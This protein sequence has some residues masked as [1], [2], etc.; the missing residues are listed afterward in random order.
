MKKCRHAS[1]GLELD[2]LGKVRP[3]CLAK[4]FVDD[5]GKEYSLHET[6]LEEIWN[7]NSRKQLL[8]DLE[9]GIEN[10]ICD[11]CWIEERHGRES[12]RNRENSRDIGFAQTPQILDL[13]LGNTCNLRCRTCNPFSSS[14]WVNEW[15][16]LGYSYGTSKTEYFEKFKNIQNLF[17]DS[18]VELWGTLEEWIPKCKFI[19]FY[20]GEPL[21]VKKI[22]DILLRSVESNLCEEQ[23]IH[24][25]TNATIFPTEDQIEILSKFKQINISL[26]IDGIR[27]KFEYMRYPG[28]W[29]I[30]EKN[31]QQY[32]DL[33]DNY[34]N[35]K[36]DFC[37]TVSI[38]NLWDIPE[39][40]EYVK[41]NYA[42]ISIYY[43]MLF[44]PEFFNITNV[45]EELK[46]VVEKRLLSY[47]PTLSNVTSML[48]SKPFNSTEFEN[49]ILTTRKHDQYRNNKFQDAF[50]NWSK[51]LNV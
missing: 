11:T 46:S 17:S 16:D 3:C 29:D 45:P 24:F 12:K 6:N 41:K 27:E 30:V 34:E 33:N 36:V 37:Y 13:K 32:R 1:F 43:N 2:T 44:T 20:G 40:D 4:P 50:P 7:S 31:I 42:S 14:S 15:Y 39:F 28:K 51:I 18:N 26:S 47:S 23:E 8:L 21:L 38:Y 35:I 22:W 10:S 5:N 25:N 49:L 9:N 19:D 48:F